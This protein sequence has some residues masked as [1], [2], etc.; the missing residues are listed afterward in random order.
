[1]QTTAVCKRKT[2]R[3]NNNEEVKKHWLRSW[4]VWERKTFVQ[5]LRHGGGHLIG[6]GTVHFGSFIKRK[7]AKMLYVGYGRPESRE[8][9]PL[10]LTN[11]RVVVKTLAKFFLKWSSRWQITDRFVLFV[12]LFVVPAVS[13]G[14][15][16]HCHRRRETKVRK[17][18]VMFI[19]RPHFFG[20]TLLPFADCNVVFVH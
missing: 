8:P 20:I 19:I 13:V 6:C 14:C 18:S 11:P 4:K 12:C 16:R 5:A 2:K 1:M 9:L 10:A 7:I 15:A 3:A 17:S